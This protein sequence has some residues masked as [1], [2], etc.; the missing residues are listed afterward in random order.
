[1]SLVEIN[2]LLLTVGYPVAYLAFPESA[3]PV[4]PYICWYVT[5]SNNFAADGV[6]Y[7][8]INTIVVELYTEK[9]DTQ[10]E[11]KIE[12]VFY[13]NGIFWEKTE[14]YLD[15]ENCYQIIYELEV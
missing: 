1:M 11:G 7:M 6:V 9:K 14:N 4:L 10:A 15:S 12:S 2:E 13:N 8:G 3:A 5:G